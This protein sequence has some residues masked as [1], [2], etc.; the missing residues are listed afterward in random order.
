MKFLTCVMPITW[1]HTEHGWGNGYVAIPKEHKLFGKSYD[2]AD[3][4]GISAHG[5]LTFAE[6]LSNVKD[7]FSTT[8]KD[9]ADWW[10]F[11]FDTAHYADTKANW[12]EDKVKEE[13]ESLKKQLENLK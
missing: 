6:N 3:E 10:V 13:T 2:F 8:K 5:G 11:G 4:A 12:T 7:L 9:R 1:L